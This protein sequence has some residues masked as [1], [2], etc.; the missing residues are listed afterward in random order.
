MLDVR[1]VRKWLRHSA[2]Q[3]ETWANL[4]PLST[5]TQL[6]LQG[7]PATL[8]VPL[9]STSPTVQTFKS[10]SSAAA[11]CSMHSKRPGVNGMNR[12][13]IQSHLYTF[14]WHPGSSSCVK[15]A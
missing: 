12:V 6:R 4:I 8:C 9:D 3:S 7:S 1:V 5:E 2:R 15:E 13:Q 11:S 10:E 14:L